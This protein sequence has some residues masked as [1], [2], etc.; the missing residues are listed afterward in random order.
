M[1]SVVYYHGQCI[2]LLT[3]HGK[4]RVIAPLFERALSCRIQRVAGYDTDQ[5]GT[6]TREI[7]RAGTQLE[8]ARRKAQIGMQLADSPYGLASEGAFGADPIAGMFAWNVECVLF[9][10][11][12]SE[13]EIVGWAQ[14]RGQHQHLLTNDWECAR[15][16]ASQAGFP[17][18]GL[19]IRPAGADDPRI[20][21]GITDWGVLRKAFDDAQSQ[22]DNRQVFVENDLRAHLNPTRMRMIEQATAN[23]IAK[24]HSPCPACHMPGFGAIASLP[25]LPCADCGAP[26]QEARGEEWACV[27]CHYRETLWYA[28]QRYADPAYCPYCNP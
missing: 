27:K 9:I 16:F 1:N 18:H 21:K 13:L 28:P 23:L 26:T 17:E 6:F 25:G 7:P 24:L 5:L 19:V 12:R 14:G 10:D 4:E 11:A 22:A 15:I 3:Q 20:H 2:A 8:A